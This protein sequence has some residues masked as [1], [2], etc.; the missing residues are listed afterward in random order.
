MGNRRQS[1]LSENGP[2][3]ETCQEQ[4]IIP[5]PTHRSAPSVAVSA[6]ALAGTSGAGRDPLPGRAGKLH[7]SR[8]NREAK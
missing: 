5:L 8:W 2:G 7:L 1:P 6:M 3:A 4:V